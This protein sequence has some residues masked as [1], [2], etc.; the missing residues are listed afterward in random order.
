MIQEM[1]KTTAKIVSKRMALPLGGLPP[2]GLLFCGFLFLLSSCGMAVPE[3]EE[4]I[5][6]LGVIETTTLDGVTEIA[7]ERNQAQVD[8]SHADSDDEFVVILYSYDFDN[9]VFGYQ[10]NHS[11]GEGRTSALGTASLVRS[12]KSAEAV[13]ATEDIHETLRALEMELDGKQA[14]ETNGRIRALSGNHNPSLGSTRN[15]NVLNSLNGVV[16][17]DTITAEL[18]AVTDDF[19]VYM[20]VRNVEA[21]TDKELAQFIN[22]F[23]EK[24]ED[25]RQLFG[26]ESDVNHD[27]HFAIL[28]SQAVNELGM[29]GG[30]SATGGGMLTGYFYGGDLY[31]ASTYPG[32]NEMEVFYMM[33]PD[34]SGEY[35][36]SLSTKFYLS[37]IAPS[38]L[39]HEFQHMISYNQHVFEN[40]GLSEEPWLNEGLSHLAE[41]I[42]SITGG[43]MEKT[44]IENPSRVNLYLHVTDS[45]C[46][47]CGSSLAQRGGSYLFLRY[48]YEQAEIGNLEGAANGSGFIGALLDTDL[49]GVENVVNAALA[50]P[51]TG[52]FKEL[53]GKFSAALF[54]S[55][56]GLTDD[57]HANFKGIN[58]RAA[59]ND[60]RSTI[61]D[62][63]SLVMPDALAFEG[64]VASSGISFVLLNGD[65]ILSGGD[66]LTVS[67]ASAMNGGG[68]VIQLK[69][70]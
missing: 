63:P 55:G 67:L 38:V 52:R 7:F 24:V 27:D 2:G 26:E 53:I 25:E 32:S 65:Q 43:Y 69:G 49:S 11:V 54:F 59:Q 4:E 42:S 22:P 34:P 46:F 60:N 3:S 17:H 68:Y 23:A 12:M 40:D 50:T 58:L 44:G 28:I 62:G 6:D 39:P 47:T 13:D 14:G 66:L 19:Y 21:L 45:T 5:E 56:T 8:F 10:L 51:E 30:G 57:S 37:N 33:T 1:I 18:R 36:V 35:G 31:D 20:D 70:E 29:A 61:L 15:F 16:S 9:E 48:L 41:D 64:T